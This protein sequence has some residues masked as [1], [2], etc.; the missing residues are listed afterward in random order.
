MTV[1]SAWLG[2]TAGNM[3][4]SEQRHA[5]L[6]CHSFVVGTSKAQLCIFMNYLR[7][8]KIQDWQLPGMQV[9]CCLPH[10]QHSTANTSRFCTRGGLSIAV[11]WTTRCCEWTMQNSWSRLAAHLYCTTLILCAL[12][13]T[14]GSNKRAP[15]MRHKV[16]TFSLSWKH[17]DACSRKSSWE[18]HT[19]A[20][21]PSIESW[22][23]KAHHYHASIQH[24][25]RCIR[26]GALLLPLHAS[27]P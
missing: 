2:Y 25:S 13:P 10:S 15:S 26:H 18:V 20:R 19:R 16:F 7:I 5:S 3:E 12:C 4:Q 1:G 6:K 22:I 23:A 17:S 24:D 11:Q 21:Q 14:C 9:C 27:I 8:G